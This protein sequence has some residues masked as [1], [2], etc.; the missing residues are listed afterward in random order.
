MWQVRQI[1]RIQA[2]VYPNVNRKTNTS[3]HTCV[4]TYKEFKEKK[5]Q[6]EL[7]PPFEVT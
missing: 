3:A 6:F 4:N 5:K 7:I 1:A 2:L